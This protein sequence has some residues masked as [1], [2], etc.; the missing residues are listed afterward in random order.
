M[1]EARIR[2]EANGSVPTIPALLYLV[3]IEAAALFPTWRLWHH[4]TSHGW[5]PSTGAE[6]A[7]KQLD[8]CEDPPDTG[9]R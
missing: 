3:E 5:S 1:S 7:G 8:E 4:L 6:V 9:G 2:V